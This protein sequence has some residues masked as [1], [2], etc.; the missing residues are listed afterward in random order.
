MLAVVLTL[1]LG[2]AMSGL[3]TRLELAYIG[4]SIQGIGASG[5]VGMV[6]LC[7]GDIFDMRCISPT[8]CDEK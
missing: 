6:N 2:S 4:R 8:V 7:I 3:A 5:T 1:I